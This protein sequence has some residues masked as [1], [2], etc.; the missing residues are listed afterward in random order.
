MIKIYGLYCLA[1][2]SAAKMV[3]I[4]NHSAQIIDAFIVYAL[5][6]CASQVCHGF[7]MHAC[8]FKRVSL[9]I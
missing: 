2:V 8:P 7:P 6:T 9:V 4:D 3:M 1:L 5:L